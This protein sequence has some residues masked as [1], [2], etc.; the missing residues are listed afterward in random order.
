M[1]GRMREG[2]ASKDR[3]NVARVFALLLG[4][5]YV[6]A[7]VA[8]FTVTGFSSGFVANTNASLI[9]F[10]LNIFHNVV[11]LAIGAALILVSRLSDV[12]ITQGVLIGVGLFY[13]LATLLG[14]LNYGALQII[15]INDPLAADN[16]LHLFSGATA[17]IF[18][19]IGV[20]QQNQSLRKAGAPAGTYAGR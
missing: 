10:D 18:G 11:H 6:V 7:G 14:F 1:E 15:S 3:G 17:L 12:T 9:G 13:V 5:G 4:A 20:R 16:F 2:S 8:G 19:L